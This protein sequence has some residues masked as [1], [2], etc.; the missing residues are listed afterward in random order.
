M[1]RQRFTDIPLPGMEGGY[2]AP[3]RAARPARAYAPDLEPTEASIRR[4]WSHVVRA[5][6]EG[7][8]IWTGAISAPDG[9]GRITWRQA[10]RSRSISAHRFALLL[11]DVSVTEAEWF[12]VAEHRCNEPLCVRLDE[13]H[14]IRSTQSANLAWAVTCGRAI[15]PRPGPGDGRTRV[16][17]SRDVRTAL[18]YGWDAG[19]YQQAAGHKHPHT[20]PTLF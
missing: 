2:V 19:R 13:A 15:G 4:F 1:R 9:Y 16:Q 10:G 7:C 8:W 5:P 14:V 6:G 18:E 17:R 12:G 3:T 11:D 20:Q